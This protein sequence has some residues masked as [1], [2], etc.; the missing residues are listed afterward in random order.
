MIAPKP[1]STALA[2]ILFLPMAAGLLAGCDYA[3]KL[4]DAPTTL[5]YELQSKKPPSV[6]GIQPQDF[7]PPPPPTDL[8]ALQL[9]EPP[10]RVAQAPTGLPSVPDLPPLPRDLNTDVLQFPSYQPEA[11]APR[12]ALVV[13]QQQINL[14]TPQSG[15]QF[16]VVESFEQTFGPAPTAI[17]TGQARIST[18]G[19]PPTEIYADT[20]NYIAQGV[21][22]QQGITVQPNSDFASYA[23]LPFEAGPVN[24][25]AS[26]T[27]DTGAYE[28]YELASAPPAFVP[29]TQSQLLY[30]AP[31]LAAPLQP[32]LETYAPVESFA[33]PQAYQAPAPT[34]ASP[35]MVIR[36][37]LN[38]GAV[39]N[40]H[41]VVGA[42]G[43]ASSLLA[44][45][46]ANELG[47]PVDE[48]A[49]RSAAAIFDL[50]ASAD[51]S[52]N[53]ARAEWKLFSSTGEL[54]GIFPESQGG[55]SWGSLGDDAV[56]AVG[57]RVADRLRRNADLRRAT[58][59][60]VASAPSINDPR[61]RQRLASG[62]PSLA[63]MPRLRPTRAAVT[64]Q[65]V[66]VPYQITTQ[67]VP[68]SRP[69]AI[70]TA[71]IAPPK[72]APLAPR[73]V[74]PRAP[75]VSDIQFQAPTPRPVRQT[76]TALLAPRPIQPPVNS[77]PPPSFDTL[78]A[79]QTAPAPSGPKALVFRGVRGAPGD[80]DQ[81]LTREV[82]RL[83]AQSGAN[84]TTNGTA[85]A[86]YLVAQVEHRRGQ[87]AD[88]I[89]ITWLVED[90]SG[91]RIGQVVQENDVPAGSLD[92]SWGEDAFYAAQGARDGIMELLKT[93]GALDA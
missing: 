17:E 83:L 75:A 73:V 21:V 7:G 2:R 60:S 81:A 14:P 50:R 72:P 26:Q 30:S 78:R 13:P 87:G 9:P 32:A 34:N 62:A 15:G 11:E 80:G 44:R 45:T 35:I 55:G 37:R 69:Q 5:G 38:N 43:S 41:P 85:D 74:S 88:S 52:G 89:K 57:R 27:V 76:Q 77:A 56:M 54:V 42:P 68:R 6:T 58:L 47:A 93:S 18:V 23:P 36:T 20:Q 49:A 10:A 70:R 46:I 59:T 40:V 53:T 24:D 4:P 92:A 71:A 67:P 16:E 48:A 65:S 64:S 1:T 61:Y 82:S 86:L 79:P 8:A 22:P 29:E 66:P 28:P 84:L 3:S 12:Q 39:V 91:T 90:A 19:T 51:R 33:A 25:F 31:P 63:P